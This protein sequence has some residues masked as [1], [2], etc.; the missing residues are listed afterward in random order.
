MRTIQIGTKLF[1]NEKTTEIY[2]AYK[3]Y[4]QVKKEYDWLIEYVICKEPSNELVSAIETYYAYVKEQNRKRDEYID[5]IASEIVSQLSEDDKQYICAHP[6]STEHHF[7]MGLG[8]RNEYIYNEDLDFDIGHPDDFSATISSRVASLIIDDYDFENPFYRCMYDDFTFTHIRRLYYAVEGK[9]PDE[10]LA[11]YADE[12][13]EYKAAKKCRQ[14]IKNMVLNASRFKKRA[15]RAGLSENQYTEFIN[16]VDAYN[17]KNWDILPY[18]IALLGSTSLAEGD[19]NKYLELL[20]AVMKQSPRVSIEMPAFVFNQRD[21]A[22]IAASEFGR[23]L[24]RFPQ[25]SKDDEIIRA[26]LNDNGEA[27]Q[28]VHKDLR[29]K[30]EYLVLALSSEYGDTLKM[31]CM[32]KYRDDDELVKVAL[33]AN[34]CNIEYASKRIRDDL[35]MAKFAITHQKNYYPESTV[36]NLSK[37]LRDCKEIALLDIREGHAC[38]SDYSARL[39]DSEEIAEAL[40]SSEHKWKLYMMSERIQKLYEQEEEE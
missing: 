35:E 23:S 40:V 26:A 16:Y 21:A 27:I 6:S 8:I 5:M 29:D 9:Y 12:P 13:D 32:A 34:G 38:V 3:D 2:E 19:R 4:F 25:F 33:E 14:K 10:I 36:C 1:E 17:A 22:L 37:R 18:D 24:Q 20:K 31:R 15:A 28:Y 30:K 7:G 39:R 11:L